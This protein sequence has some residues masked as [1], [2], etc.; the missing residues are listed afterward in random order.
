MT[1]RSRP[2]AT[3]RIGTASLGGAGPGDPAGDTVLP[4]GRCGRVLRARLTRERCG[5]P[6]REF[7]GGHWVPAAVMDEAFRWWLKGHSPL[8]NARL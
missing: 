5:V 8:L 3:T 6:Y 2:K 1:A 7:N 4:I